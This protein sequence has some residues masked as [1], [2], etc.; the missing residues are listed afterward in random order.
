MLRKV[1]R[2][3]KT[4]TVFYRDIQVAMNRQTNIDTVDAMHFVLLC[5]FI[6]L[7]I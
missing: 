7:L 3:K 5:I 6:F 2:A 1:R 4:P